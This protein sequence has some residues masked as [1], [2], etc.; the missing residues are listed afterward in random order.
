MRSADWIRLD[1]K[2]LPPFGRMLVCNGVGV[3][4]VD[5]VHAGDGDPMRGDVYAFTDDNRTAC[6][7]THYAPIAMP[8]K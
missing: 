5:M 8:F 7:L 3:W 2:N 1:P 4:T 6:N